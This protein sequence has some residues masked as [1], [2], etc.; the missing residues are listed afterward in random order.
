MEFVGRTS[1]TT[2]YDDLHRLLTDFSE[3]MGVGHAAYIGCSLAHPN[4]EPVSLSTYSREWTE[5][6]D[7]QSLFEVDPVH[8][9]TKELLLP[10]IWN[11][12]QEFDP[13]ASSFMRLASDFGAR[14]QGIAVPV[15]GP[16]GDK[17]LISIVARADDKGWDDRRDALISELVFFAQNFHAAIVET[18]QRA[19]PAPPQLT[20]RER[21]VML[22]AAR[23]K[24]AWETGAILGLQESTVVSYIRQVCHKLDVASKY[25]AVAI[26]VAMRL[27]AP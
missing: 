10:Y 12:R 19:A 24:T 16:R 4:D 26:C 23:G 13:A 15:R 22:W 8:R 7:G 11:D 20:P 17:G 6:Y 27:V 21:D 25:E 5:L 9:D 14:A 1:R 3:E 18:A 2:G